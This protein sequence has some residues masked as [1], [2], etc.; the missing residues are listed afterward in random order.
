MLRCCVHV[1]ILSDVTHHKDELLVASCSYVLVGKKPKIHF[2]QTR[3]I[4]NFVKGRWELKLSEQ[5]PSIEFH[6]GF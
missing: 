6:Q 2:N 1:S 3:N 4:I 5:R